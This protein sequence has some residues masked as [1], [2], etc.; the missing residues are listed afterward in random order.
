M[1]STTK[2]RQYGHIFLYLNSYL[3]DISDD[4]DEIIHVLYIL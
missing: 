4:V 3:G 1:T 2:F